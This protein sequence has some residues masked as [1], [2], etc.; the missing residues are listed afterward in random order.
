[1]EDVKVRMYMNG[2]MV[3][4]KSLGMLPPGE[5][6]LTFTMSQDF[7]DMIGKS[8]SFK[9]ELQ[10]GAEV[11]QA[12]ENINVSINKEDALVDY[13]K[14]LVLQKSAKLPSGVKYQDY[15]DQYIDVVSQ[16]YEA[17]V[18]EVLATMRATDKDDVRKVKRSLQPKFQ[19]DRKDNYK[20]RNP[21]IILR[22]YKERP[23][24]DV[25]PRRNSR[26]KKVLKDMDSNTK[27]VLQ[28]L[29]NRNVLM[30]RREFL[31][32]DRKSGTHRTRRDGYANTVCGTAQVLYNFL[33]N[34]ARVREGK[35]TITINVKGAKKREAFV[36]DEN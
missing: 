15:V 32:F 33:E 20:S 22:I 19:L 25:K 7:F 27:A 9:V 34:T 1:M 28:K 21:S 12:R 13:F 36:C 3:E 35:E 6:Q 23:F 30:L 24:G 2:A 4:E 16:M 11:I 5:H 18:Q 29:A 31:T 10:Y 26:R 14:Y 8:Y 17:E